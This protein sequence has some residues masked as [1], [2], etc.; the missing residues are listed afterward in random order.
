MDMEEETDG[1]VFEDPFG[2]DFEEEEIVEG[3]DSDEEGGGMEEDEQDTEE[4]APRCHTQA[5]PSC[6]DVPVWCRFR[7]CYVVTA[8]CCQYNQMD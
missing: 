1:L 5:H 8:T 6:F 2:D 7:Y 3:G 4:V